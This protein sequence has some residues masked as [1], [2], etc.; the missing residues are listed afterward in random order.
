MPRKSTTSAKTGSGSVKNRWL[1]TT[2]RRS[3]PNRRLQPA[4]LVR[5]PAAGHVGVVL[6]RVRLVRRVGDQLRLLAGQPDRLQLQRPLERLGLEAAGGLVGVRRV[7]P[8]DRVTQQHE[9]LDARQVGGD[10]LPGQRVEH[11]VRAGLAGDRQP[12]RGRRGPAGGDLQREVP[13]I[14]GRPV[15][16]AGVEVVH[17]LVQHRRQHHRVL[18]QRLVH[19][20]RAAALRADDEE[21]RRHPGRR[22]QPPGRPG[23]RPR[24]LL[25]PRLLLH[26]RP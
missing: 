25:Q 22:G 19:R 11:V 2:C 9:Q 10:P 12:A 13:A 26:R 4:Q 24:Q 17:A 21:R 23:R 3:R 14:P 5:V 16:V 7:R 18:G 8:L 6:V 1:S 15:P 20:R